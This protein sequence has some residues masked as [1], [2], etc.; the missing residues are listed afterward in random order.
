MKRFFLLFFILISFLSCQKSNNNNFKISIPSEPTNLD[1]RKSGDLVSSM[2]SFLLFQGLTE[3][4]L[5]GKIEMALAKSYTVSKDKKTYT[6]FLKDVYWSDGAPITAY[7]FEK[8]WKKIIDPSF[9]SLCSQLLYCIKNA[10]KAA[11][12]E[13]SLDEVKINAIDSKTLKIELE[14]PTPY[15][16]SLIS[17]CTFFPIPSHIDEKDPNWAYNNTKNFVCSGPYKL[18]EWHP[19]KQLIVEKNQHFWDKNRVKINHIE[20]N[21]IDNEMTALQMFNNKELDWFGSPLHSLPTDTIPEI[22]KRKELFLTSVGGLRFCAFNTEVFPFNNKNMR[23]AFAY[24]INRASIVKNVTQLNEPIATRCIPPVLIN[25][26][27]KELINDNDL[28]KA[29]LYFNKALKELNIDKN[30]INFKFSYSSVFLEKKIAEAMQKTW[31]NAFN[32]K[33]VLEQ[34]EKKMFLDNLHKHNFQFALALLIVQYNDPMNIFE[35]FKYKMHSKNYSSWENNNFIDLL[36]NINRTKDNILR[37]KIIEEAE[38]LFID[39]M[40]IA[41]IYHYTYATLI[42]PYLKNA[43]IGSV[44]DLHFDEVEFSQQWSNE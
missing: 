15:F 13:A 25:N 8:S 24:A 10:E 6:F 21:V 2:F 1:T 42:Q 19:N 18:K 36:N 35:R 23:K 30:N 38:E 28:E 5:S 27:N 44:G 14:N 32:I 26:E 41:P 22:L 7:D 29:R 9:P 33:I 43:F 37:K 3:L 20:I 39:E 16:L 17:F 34:V 11:K 12:K 4:R 31:E 40:P